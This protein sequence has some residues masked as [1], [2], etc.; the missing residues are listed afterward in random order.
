MPEWPS[1]AGPARGVPRTPDL[2]V[3]EAANLHTVSALVAAAA[4]ARP[5]P[6]DPDAPP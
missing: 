2:G 1:Q 4:L 5:G 6:P 3:I